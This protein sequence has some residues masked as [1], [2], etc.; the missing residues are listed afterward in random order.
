M[1][2][3]QSLFY[4][5]LFVF[6]FHYVKGYQHHHYH[7]HHHNNHNNHQ[8]VDEIGSPISTKELRKVS[9]VIFE[10]LPSGLFTSIDVNYQGQRETKDAKDEAPEPLFFVPLDLFEVLPPIE[11][12]RKLYDN[13]NLN[14]HYHEHVTL[15]EDIEENQF[16]NSLLEQ[17][18][19]VYTMD[20]LASKGYFAKNFHEY[21]RILKDLW[22]RRF[23]RFNETALGSS[24]FEHVFLVEK[25]HN[26]YITGLHN[27][28]FF[29]DEENSNKANYL[30]YVAK[31]D[32]HKK[33]AILK[34]YVSYLGKTKLTSMFI[35]TP[36]E[37]EIALYTLC[38]F[39]RPN[40][41]CKVTL[42]N[43]K[44]AIMTHSESID[45]QQVI[46][47]AFPKIYA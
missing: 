1:H 37:F 40:K 34:F 46:S 21:K 17:E 28:I 27:W 26:R 7:H 10:L 23:S 42:G 44:V 13:Y 11:L 47:T 9:E 4:C 8:P 14:S 29:A 30:G 38:H 15:E 5:L 41:V 36:P 43:V 45:N 31:V 25:K 18:L 6:T 33:A 24:G 12:M 16:I 20:F 32:L 19:L 22:F 39:A 35:G 2:V 3:I